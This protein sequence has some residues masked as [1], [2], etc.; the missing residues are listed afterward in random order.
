MKKIRDKVEHWILSADQ[1]W[2]ALPQKWQRLFTKLFLAGYTVLTI[3]VLIS[4]FVTT[5]NDNNTMSI[6]HITTISDHTAVKRPTQDI[7]RGSNIKK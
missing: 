1:K 7:K 5:A 4:I 6:G 2:K 3:L